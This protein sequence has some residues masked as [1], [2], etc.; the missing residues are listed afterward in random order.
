MNLIFLVLIF[1]YWIYNIF[2]TNFFVGVLVLVFT[3]HIYKIFK[4]NK[5]IEKPFIV[6]FLLVLLFQSIT[7]QK[8]S[9]TNIANDDR[10]EIDMR[11]KAYPPRFLRVGYWLEERK[12]SIAFTRLSNN[13]FENID[14]NLYFFANHPRERVGI[15][16][17]EKFPYIL[18]PAFLVGLLSL[19][20][21]KHA[22][23]WRFSFFIPLIFLTVIG[24]INPMGPFV[25]FPFFVIT[26]SEGLKPLE[27]WIKRKPKYIR[28][29]IIIIFV[30]V[31]I[32]GI[33]YEIY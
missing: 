14:P 18:F 15:R 22:N 8:S 21:K 24:N 1:N 17:F 20:K 5:K 30:L 11:L 9:L 13:F 26:I 6:I 10:R 3:L 7:T 28:N 29:L 32:Q 12:E 31:F 19:L 25:L 23:F 16:E 27:K 2:S 33:S 4:C